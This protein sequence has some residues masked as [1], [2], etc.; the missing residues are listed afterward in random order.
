MSVQYKNCYVQTC[1]IT[2]EYKQIMKEKKCRN[3]TGIMFA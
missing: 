1:K 2:L 3:V